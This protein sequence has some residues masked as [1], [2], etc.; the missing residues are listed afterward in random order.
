M[1]SNYWFQNKLARNPHICM[2]KMWVEN[3]TTFQ[4]SN[5]YVIKVLC[6]CIGW[7]HG[8]NE[9][10]WKRD[11][12]SNFTPYFVQNTLVQNGKLF[13]I[14]FSIRLRE[15]NFLMHTD[16]WTYYIWSNDSLSLSLL[17]FFAHTMLKFQRRQEFNEI[18]V[19]VNV[20]LCVFEFENSL[21][22]IRFAMGFYKC[23]CIWA[24]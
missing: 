12:K 6:W 19:C 13:Y 22:F 11:S 21:H 4:A 14:A 23:L 18:F 5:M 1:N 17:L 9:R 20:C 15:M 16:T 8:A 2:Q 3:A 24:Q 7:W 10:V